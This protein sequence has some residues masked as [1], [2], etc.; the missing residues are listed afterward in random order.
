M[1]C[2][3]CGN[4]AGSRRICQ[5]C[6]AVLSPPSAAAPAGQAAVAV[7]TPRRRRR[8]FAKIAIGTIAVLML[9]CTVVLVAA[10]V[11]DPVG[12]PLSIAAAVVPAFVYSLL[13]L[14]LDKYEKE[15]RRA[16]IGAFAWGA[17]GAVLFSLVAEVIADGILITAVGQDAG[18]FLSLGIGAPIIEETFKGLALLG[19]LWF[20][21]GE[22]DNLLDGLVYGALIGL[23]FAMTENML[24]FGAEYRHGG[25][26][27]LGRLFVARAVIDGFG[28]ALYT[29]T[30]G[31]AV[32]WARGRYRRGTLRYVVPLLGWGL[33]V[34]QHFLW[35]TGSVVIAGLQG[36]DATVFSVILVEAPLFTLPALVI[37]FLIARTASKRELVILREQLAAEVQRGVLTPAEYEVLTTKELRQHAARQAKQQGKLAIETQRRFFQTAAEL[38]FR[39]YHLRRGEAPKPGQE[40]PE[41]AYR[42]ELANLRQ[43]LAAAGLTPTLAAPV[44]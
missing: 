19:L 23:G 24:Y 8:R 33:A 9:A 34:F 41:D 29:G 2:P 4:E 25:M 6:G 1:I 3:N 16:L 40:A 31:A 35:N 28:H 43:Q 42:A 32:G 30:T 15:P 14:S 13:V 27:D 22:L 12:L 26:A 20:Y 17:V 37:L 44:T 21:R 11:W 5:H 36:Q 18:T 7:A 10:S 38:A 39:T